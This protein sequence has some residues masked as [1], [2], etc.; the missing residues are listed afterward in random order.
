VSRSPVD[1]LTVVGALGAVFVIATSWLVRRD[2]MRGFAYE[3]RVRPV[4]EPRARVVKEPRVR[5]PKQPRVRPVK[6]PRV[7]APKAPRA[8]VV[9]EPRARRA[10]AE[11]SRPV[12]QPEQLPETRE[13]LSMPD[14]RRESLV[15][16]LDAFTEFKSR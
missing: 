11:R 5:P 12:P 4:K 6:E 16:N 1:V 9:K 2:A 10:P 7:R 15:L 14:P 8:Q 13:A 3:P